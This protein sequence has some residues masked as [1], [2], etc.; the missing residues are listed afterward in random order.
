MISMKRNLFVEM[1]IIILLYLKSRK[2]GLI[3]KTR[4]SGFIPD[5]EMNVWFSS[6][7]GLFCSA[8]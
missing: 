6:G 4:K 2:G 7:L 1:Q 5:S 8:F 3:R